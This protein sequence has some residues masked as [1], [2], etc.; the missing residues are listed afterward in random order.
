VI[1]VTGPPVSTP[2]SPTTYIRLVHEHARAFLQQRD[3]ETRIDIAVIIGAAHDDV[4]GITRRAAEKGADPIRGRRHLF[5]HLLQ[6]HDHLPRIDD[7]LFLVGNPLAHREQ[8]V[9]EW[10][11]RVDESDDAIEGLQDA[12]LF[13]AGDGAEFL[14][15]VVCFVAHR[16]LPSRTFPPAASTIRSH[17][18][19]ANHGDVPRRSRAPPTRQKVVDGTDRPTYPASPFEE[20]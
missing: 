10:V 13:H 7:D 5:D 4:R 12:E 15:F 6:L 19:Q 1:F 17:R 3:V 2:R 18:L 8:L 14:K 16:R 20:S 11:A 9:P